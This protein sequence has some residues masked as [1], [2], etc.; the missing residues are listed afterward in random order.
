MSQLALHLTLAIVAPGDPA[1]ATAAGFP[2]E[3]VTA[4]ETAM[5][6]A[7]ARAEPSVV[8]IVRGRVGDGSVTYAVRGNTAILPRDARTAMID[9]SEISDPDYL[10]MPGDFGSGVVIGEKGEILTAFHVVKGAGRIYVRASGRHRVR[11]RGDRLRPP[12]RPGRARSTKWTR[13]ADPGTQA[14]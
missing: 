4:L 12:Q 2:S 9:L 1:P 10:P 5:T 7:I 13:R 11:R 6:D 14:P 8:A 3:S